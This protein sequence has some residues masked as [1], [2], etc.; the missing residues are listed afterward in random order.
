MDGLQHIAWG[1]PRREA[2]EKYLREM[3]ADVTL[4]APIEPNSCRNTAPLSEIPERAICTANHAT[5]LPG[6]IL[7]QSPLRQDLGQACA[8]GRLAAA[9]RLRRHIHDQETSKATNSVYLLF[10]EQTV[11][12]G[13]LLQLYSSLESESLPSLD[14]LSFAGGADLA[15]LGDLPPGDL[16]SLRFF[17][18]TTGD[19]AADE[20]APAALVFSGAFFQFWAA[21]ANAIL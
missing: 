8:T 6:V 17:A 3:G 5:P 7:L 16:A 1:D 15:F 11:Y 21:C 12:C 14:E 2:M 18:E 19:A 4:T 9:L 13:R 10:Y 20:G